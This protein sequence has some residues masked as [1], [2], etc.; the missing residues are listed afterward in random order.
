MVVPM[1][2]THSE[3]DCSGEDFMWCRLVKMQIV[4]KHEA[5]LGVGDELVCVRLE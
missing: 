1:F 3:N 5:L 2:K 4:N